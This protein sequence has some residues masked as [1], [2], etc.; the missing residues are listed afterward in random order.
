[1]TVVHP[2][3]QAAGALGLLSDREME[4]LALVAG[5][6]TN[7]EIGERL[8][9]AEQTVE[10]HVHH[11]LAKLRVHHRRHAARLYLRYHGI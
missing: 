2:L 6:L 1:M 3:D 10:S 8:V 4:V 5:H 11:I 9:N 7:R